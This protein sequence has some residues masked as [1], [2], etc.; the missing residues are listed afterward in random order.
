[1]SDKDKIQDLLQRIEIIEKRNREVELNKSWEGSWAR[2]ILIALFTYLSIALYFQYI[3]EINPWLNA[4]VPTVGFILST[5]TLSFFKEL[6][7]KYFFR[8]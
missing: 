4:I 7:I 1:M 8:K 5:M 2:K 6:W 3:L